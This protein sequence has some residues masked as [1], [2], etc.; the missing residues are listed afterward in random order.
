MKKLTSSC[1]ITPWT[2]PA[3]LGVMVGEEYEYVLQGRR[4]DLCGGKE[5]LE[6]LSLSL[7]RRARL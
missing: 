3:N 7:A 5:L 1:I 6:I 4:G 2:L